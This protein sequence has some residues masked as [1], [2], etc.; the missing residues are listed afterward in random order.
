MMK[1][2]DAIAKPIFTGDQMCKEKSTEAIEPAKR[3]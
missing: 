2:D 1:L 3:D